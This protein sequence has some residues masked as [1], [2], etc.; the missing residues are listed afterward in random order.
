MNIKKLALG[1]A[2]ACTALAAASPAYA[3]EFYIGEVITVAFSYCPNGTLEAAGQTLPISQYQAL[4]ALYGVTYGGNGTTNFVLPDLRGRSVIG[5]GQGPGL[6]A[7]PQGQ[8]GGTENTTLT[9]Q[10]MPA[11]IHFGSLN[12]SSGGPS[13]NDPAGSALATFP[14]GTP[15]FA[16]G[17]PTPS[18]AMAPGAVTIGLA[19]GN[20]PFSIIDPYLTLRQCVIINGIFPSRP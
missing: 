4:F 14:T 9:T 17:T 6:T 13:A 20:Q 18:V 15:V 8:P 7:H 10:Q 1:A 5:Q 19:G 2:T 11:H 3:Q 16:T 12:G